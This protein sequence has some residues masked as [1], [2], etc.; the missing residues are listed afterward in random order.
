MEWQAAEGRLL[1]EAD[2]A[3]ELVEKESMASTDVDGIARRSRRAES[4]LHTRLWVPAATAG[5]IALGVFVAVVGLSVLRPSPP[6]SAKPTPSPTPASS[7]PTAGQS[8]MPTAAPTLPGETPGPSAA[9]PS[10]VRYIPALTID[11][12]FTAAY[13]AG[14][15]CQSLIGE[16]PDNPTM[17]ELLCTKDDQAAGL[18]YTL[19][20]AY[21]TTDRLNEVHLDASPVST[22]VDPAKAYGMFHSVIVL[23]FSGS[24]REAVVSWFATKLDGPGCRP[25]EQTYGQVTIG[26]ESSSVAGAGSI[27]IIGTTIT[28]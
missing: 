23:P 4:L 22:T 8:T 18:R 16:I 12:V 14:F 7:S 28:P 24:S 2:A 11:A 20:A 17:Y 27:T 19:T 9:A 21:W 25:C 10:G 6:V 15:S 1:P 5:A 26:V 13:D 3:A